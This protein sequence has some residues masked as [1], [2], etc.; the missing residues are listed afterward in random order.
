MR[1][2]W[3][4]T[5][6]AGGT[7][8]FVGYVVI[9]SL[10]SSSDQ[11]WVQLPL[12]LAVIAALFVSGSAHGPLPIAV[13]LFVAIE[14]VLVGVL[15]DLVIWLFVRRRQNEKPDLTRKKA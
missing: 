15:V 9:A 2:K 7:L 13:Y 10:V 6:I 5:A 1:K 11:D 3:H 12:F 14:A 4:A 8:L